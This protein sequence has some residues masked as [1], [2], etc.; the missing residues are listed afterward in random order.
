MKPRLGICMW[1]GIWPPSKPLMATPERAVWPLPPRP[2]VLPTPEP[3][4][5]P[6]RTRF[7]LAPALSRSSFKRAMV[8]VLIYCALSRR[9]QTAHPVQPLLFVADDAH[10]VRDLVD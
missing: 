2:P 1:S 6:P 3:M 4:P 9:R 8:V 7:L 10:Q 5:R